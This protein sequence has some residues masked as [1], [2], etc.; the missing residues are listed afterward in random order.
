MRDDEFVWRGILD[1]THLCDDVV[2][3]S[4]RLADAAKEGDWSTVFGLLDDPEQRVDVNWWRPGGTAWFTA[5]HQ[6][7]WHGAPID[8]VVELIARGP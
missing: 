8:V 7:A 3:A 2:A 5:L 4:H 1:P 6:A